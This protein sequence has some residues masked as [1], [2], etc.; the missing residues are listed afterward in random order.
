M[1]T[2]PPPATQIHPDRIV[3]SRDRPVLVHVFAGF[4]GASCLF[5]ASFLCV[6]D[7]PLTPFH[8]DPYAY[9]VIPHTHASAR[10][11]SAL[12]V[13][14]RLPTF[15]YQPLLRMGCQAFC[16]GIHVVSSLCMRM[17]LCM[18]LGCLYAVDG[19]PARD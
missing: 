2:Y 4:G 1:P 7:Y 19:I 8:H 17:R 15:P 11:R 18:R 6:R 16:G 9:P 3:P 14:I 13:T 12:P 5:L 10:H